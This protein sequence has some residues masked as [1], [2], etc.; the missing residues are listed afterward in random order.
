MSRHAFT[1]FSLAIVLAVSPGFSLAQAPSSRTDT[2]APLEVRAPV[3]IYDLTS[4]ENI[5]EKY[6]RDL[7]SP[8]VNPQSL[9]IFAGGTFATLTL[10]ATA[11]DFEDHILENVSSNR[12]LGNFSQ[13]GD[14]AG[15]LIPNI[16]YVGYFGTSYLF[17]KDPESKFRAELMFRATLAATSMSTVLKLV[18]REPRPG[19]ADEL[20][21]FPSGHSTSIFAFATTLA[22]MHGPYW[23][24]GAFA[25]ATFVAFSRMNDN[26]HRLHDVVAGATIGSMYGLSV[27]QRMAG[28]QN[29]TTKPAR[30]FEY[31]LI[32]VAT[33]DGAMLGL[34]GTF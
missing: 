8:F 28:R 3:K 18:V 31:E 32:P 16:L 23:G 12:P 17:T 9:S 27:Y 19:V 2:P 6:Y 33:S 11:K 14:L 21:S 1:A 10:L 26:R 15:Q 4:E 22:A 25:L 24:G 7:Y 20:T 30:R 29:S 13:F 5:F 34:S